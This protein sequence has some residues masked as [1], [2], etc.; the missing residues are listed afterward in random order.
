MN[1]TTHFLSTVS[2]KDK[3]ETRNTCSNST[4]NPWP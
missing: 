4:T 3:G 2:E 1:G